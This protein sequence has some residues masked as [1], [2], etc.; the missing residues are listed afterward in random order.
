MPPVNGIGALDTHEQRSE[1]RRRALKA[2]DD[3]RQ[4]TAVLKG[5][6]RRSNQRERCMIRCALTPRGRRRRSR[7]PRP[8]DAGDDLVGARIVVLTCG[9]RVLHLLEA[10]VEVNVIRGCPARGERFRADRERSLLTTG[11]GRFPVRGYAPLLSRIMDDQG[12]R[13]PERRTSDV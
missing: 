6:K 13:T 1:T 7:A 5:G 3:S 2:F 9:I 10:G 12:E 8:V 11:S 4:Q